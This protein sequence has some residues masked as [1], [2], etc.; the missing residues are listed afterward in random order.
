MPFCSFCQTN[1]HYLRS[2]DGKTTCPVLLNTT[3]YRCNKKGHTSK[4]C[5]AGLES[6]D[7]PAL[8]QVKPNTTTQE[9][10]KTT[11][12]NTI[13]ASNRPKTVIDTIKQTELKQKEKAK[14]IAEE[15]HQAWLQRTAEREQKAQE[16][17]TR[18]IE[19]MQAQYGSRWYAYVYHTPNDC[20]E[21]QRL[22]DLEDEE[23]Y[24]R[25]ERMKQAE[26]AYE[27]EYEHNRR[28]MTKEEFEEWQEE[29]EHDFADQPLRI[30]SEIRMRNQPAVLAHYHKTG[31]IYHPADFTGSE[32]GA[33]LKPGLL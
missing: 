24:Q 29:E 25:E 3:C 12:W 15:K 26:R 1:T 20:N 18:H 30:E 4:V 21:A 13:V 7:F 2:K 23:A 16:R 31:L 19:K 8:T 11:S 14:Q 33:P 6:A 10:P 27:A 5:K 9:N 17:E 28:T 22:R 32:Y